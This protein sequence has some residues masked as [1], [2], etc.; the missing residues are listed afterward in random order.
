MTV[1]LSTLLETTAQNSASRGVFE[2][3]NYGQ[4]FSDNS[5]FAVQFGHVMTAETI[6]IATPG[7]AQLYTDSRIETSGA[8]CSA[9][10]DG[11]YAHIH[12]GVSL[13][14]VTLSNVYNQ[15]TWVNIATGARSLNTDNTINT[16]CHAAG[17]DG[18]RYLYISGTTNI[19][20]LAQFACRNI[21]WYIS[22]AAPSV[23]TAGL[24]QEC[25]GPEPMLNDGSYYLS[26][27]VRRVGSDLHGNA[28]SDYSTTVFPRKSSDLFSV[29]SNNSI[30][31]SIG[32]SISI[33]TN[34]W[35]LNTN[36]AI[37]SCATDRSRIINH[38]YYSAQGGYASAVV[39]NTVYYCRFDQ[40]ASPALQFGDLSPGS[41]S[42]LDAA[43][44]T[45]HSTSTMV[46]DYSRV[47]VQTGTSN[48]TTLTGNSTL[49]YLTISTPGNSQNFGNTL[50]ERRRRGLGYSGA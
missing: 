4:S 1:N 21:M 46:S 25:F 18:S 32:Q 41:I 24:H 48:N 35:T 3:G 39:N 50:E 49:I 45:I 33:S 6:T 12:E 20:S 9:A 11:V 38:S 34:S 10:S 22:I 26:G 13:D 8:F 5:V 40:Q 36:H 47:V 14:P 17:S 15:S 27:P 42:T 44:N 43:A 2:A 19:D 7:T 23:M 29:S 16:I 37:G 30:I 28:T 31:S